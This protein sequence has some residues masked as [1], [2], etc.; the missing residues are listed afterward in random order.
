MEM[1]EHDML[2]TLLEK[3]DEL[4]LARNNFLNATITFHKQ[5][6]LKKLNRVQIELLHA[7]DKIKTQLQ[8]EA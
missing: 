4:A 7:R 2:L 1:T 5:E 6:A 8:T 3:L